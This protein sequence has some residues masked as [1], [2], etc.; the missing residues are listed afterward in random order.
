MPVE[1][2]N[3]NLEK[4]LG[5]YIFY[6]ISLFYYSDNSLLIYFAK[7]IN[8][9]KVGGGTGPSQIENHHSIVPSFLLGECVTLYII[10]NYPITHH[11]IRA[12]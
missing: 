2:N 12:I 11:C 1:C 5:A 10:K 4:K 7:I 3:K 8:P 9:L 6:F